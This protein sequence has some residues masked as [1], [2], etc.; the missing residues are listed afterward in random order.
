LLSILRSYQASD[1]KI[2]SQTCV[3]ASLMFELLELSQ[4]LGTA[5][6]N[7]ARNTDL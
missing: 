2:K 6:N 3:R 5:L 1:I 7:S 4:V